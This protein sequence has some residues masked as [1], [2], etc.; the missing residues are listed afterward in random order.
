MMFITTFLAFAAS[1]AAAT[2]G[3]AMAPAAQNTTQ[4]PGLTAASF[5]EMIP[6]CAVSKIQ[7]P[8]TIQHEKLTNDLTSAHATITPSTTTAATSTT[9]AAIAGKRMS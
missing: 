4:Y 8:H 1:V 7:R 6:S 3:G 9:S 2:T 5:Y